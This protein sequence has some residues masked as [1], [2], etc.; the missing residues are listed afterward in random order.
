MASN[1]RIFSHQNSDNLHLKLMG[2]FN[3]SSAHELMNM[4]RKYR[5]ISK[6]VFIHT[7]SLSSI[8]PFGLDVFQ[9]DCVFN[10]LSQWLTF[11][12]AY[13]STMAPKGSMLR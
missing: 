4:L 9:K 11:T 3:D 2:D 8:H 13:G 10:K 12:G 5:G 6:R 7:S 1:F